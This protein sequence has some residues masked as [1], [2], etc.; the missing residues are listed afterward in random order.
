MK[1]GTRTTTPTDESKKR[2]KYSL[3]FDDKGSQCKA[4]QGIH[5]LSSSKY[6]QKAVWA[7]S[8]VWFRKIAVSR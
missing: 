3:R 8:M 1:R 2:G 4:E 7:L 5:P 6:R